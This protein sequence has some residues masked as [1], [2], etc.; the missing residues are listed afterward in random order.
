M[1]SWNGWH[2]KAASP[3]DPTAYYATMGLNGLV[4]YQDVGVNIT[5]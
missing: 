4:G 1:M 5:W 2:S 3:K